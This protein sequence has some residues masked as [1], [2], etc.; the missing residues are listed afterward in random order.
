MENLPPAVFYG[1]II[2]I[3]SFITLLF[4][5]LLTYFWFVKKNLGD[6]NQ[7]R[8]FD[9]KVAEQISKILQEARL[10][11]ENI[12]K[13]ANKESQQIIKSAQDYKSERQKLIQQELEKIGQ[14]YAKQFEEIVSQ[15]QN[16]VGESLQ[17]IPSQINESVSAEITKFQENF[18]TELEN[19]N[20]NS[21]QM[22][23]Q[24]YQKYK[25][26]IETYKQERYKQIDDSIIDIVKV[27]A[28]KV[29]SK[30]I[31]IDEHE[32]IVLKTL[33]EAKKKNLI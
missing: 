16:Q 5:L 11:A 8:I 32:K 3:V 4:G 21:Q 7:K 28:R 19:M 2:I 24:A 30:Q 25:Q 27:V 17:S 13:N 12:R 10:E 20:L 23:D 18:K 22:M 1:L 6:Q 29:L 33:E 26:D 9:Q 15:L 14:T 31:S